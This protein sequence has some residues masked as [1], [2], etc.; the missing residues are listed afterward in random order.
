MTEGYVDNSIGNPLTAQFRTPKGIAISRSGNL[1][2]ADTLNHVIRSIKFWNCCP[3]G[4]YWSGE[5]TCALAPAGNGCIGGRSSSPCS[6]DLLAHWCGLGYF[7]PGSGIIYACAAGYYSTPG[8]SACTPCA[9]GT[10]SSS[11]VSSACIDS[12]V[13]L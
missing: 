12:P 4:F 9:A 2:V 10:Y 3:G 11:T 7:S 5:S 1:F 8:S 13:G 6:L